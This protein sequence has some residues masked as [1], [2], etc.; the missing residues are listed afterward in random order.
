MRPSDIL[1][2]QVADLEA[3]SLWVRRRLYKGDLDVPK[4]KR[5]YRQVARTQGT[6]ALLEA[7]R[8]FTGDDPEDWLFPCESGG[9][10]RRDNAW[11][12]YIRP[13]LK[14]LGLL[15]ATFQVMRRTFATLSKKAGV[16]AHTPS[17]QMGNTV[18]VNEIEYAVA[19]F[20]QKLAAVR[21]LESTVIQ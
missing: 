3:D 20:E 7:W 8:Q 18:D 6:V 21:H 2:L 9:P 16:D 5:S 11:V 13:K 12:R 14:P 10:L 15:W 4:T 1:A 17:A 19:T